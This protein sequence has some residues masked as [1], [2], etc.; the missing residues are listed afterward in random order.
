MIKHLLKMEDLSTADLYTLLA[1]AAQLKHDLELGKMEPYLHG[2]TLGLFFQK[3]ST[4]TRVSFE[5]GMSQLGGHSLYLNGNDMQTARGEAIKDTARVLSGYLDG[6]MIRTYHQAD[7]EE[8]AHWGSIPIINGLTD[9][10]HP[11]QVLADLMTI[12]EMKG[13]IAGQKIAFVGDGNNMANSL[14]PGA[15]IAGA[16]IALACPSGYLP[17][18]QLISKYSNHADFMLTDDPFQAV[19]DADVVITDVWSSMGNEDE[20]M[21]RQKVF[22]DGKYQLNDRLMAH[23]KA[24]AIVL[25]CLPAHREEEIT[26]KVFEA[27]SASIFREANNRLHAQK[28]VLVHLL[29]AEGYDA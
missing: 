22:A 19:E 23:A 13:T 1:T 21:Q 10:S 3:A 25:H 7:V 28:A 6:L 20:A 2:K 15:L 5:V 8:Y 16:Q 11:C 14:I 26:D 18:A 24:D 9:Y 17:N 12:Q 27:H 4:R 29:G